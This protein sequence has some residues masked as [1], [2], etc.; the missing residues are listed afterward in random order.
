MPGGGDT[1]VS[2]LVMVPD[3]CDF[4]FNR[5]WR[6][7]NIPLLHR[8]GPLIERRETGESCTHLTQTSK[9]SPKIRRSPPNTEEWGECCVH[10][11][12]ASTQIQ[13]RKDSV[14][15]KPKRTRYGGRSSWGRKRLHIHWWPST[16]EGFGSQGTHVN[17]W[18][19]CC[20]PQL[21]VWGGYW[22]QVG[23]GQ[24][25]CQTWRYTKQSPTTKGYVARTLTV[26]RPESPII[27]KLVDENWG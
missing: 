22:L 10:E 11:G 26:P 2:D 21:S 27:D 13:R 14:H 17:V 12:H 25:W 19:R 7:A 16:R 20:L 18:R 6:Q 24:G 15:L 4:W 5:W 3:I 8:G 1:L 9:L 23:G